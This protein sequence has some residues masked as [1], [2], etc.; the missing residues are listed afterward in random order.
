[1]WLL[2]GVTRY[3]KAQ[4]EWMRPDEQDTSYLLLRIAGK[5]YRIKFANSA[6]VTATI[7]EIIGSD[8]VVNLND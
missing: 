8:T 1:V 2:I 6:A 4:L 3:N 7:T 5:D